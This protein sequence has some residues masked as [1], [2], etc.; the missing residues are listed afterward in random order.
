MMRPAYAI[1]YDCIDPTA[2]RPTLETKAVR[3]LYGA[4]Q[5]NGSSGYEEAAVQ[6]F[7]AGVNAALKLLG[8]EPLI[9]RRSR[10]LHRHPHRRPG[11]QGHP[12]ALP[13]D[14]QPH[15][16]TACCC[17]RTTQTSRLCPIGFRIGL[18][19]AERLR[20]VEEK[21]AAVEREI[22]RL[23]KTGVPGSAAL[24]DLLTARGTAPVADGCRLIDLLRRPQVGYDDL[25]PFDPAPPGLPP[26]VREQV[27]ITVKYEGY[28]RRQEKQVEEFEKLERRRLPPDMDYIHIQ[29][30]RLEARE[31]LAALRPENLGQAGRI[32]GVSPADIAALMVY[33][34]TRET[35]PE[36]GTS[37]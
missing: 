8:R 6:G 26:A 32:S 11:D 29:G 33:L 28:I 1:E 5:F 4:G 2:L 10:K 30:L 18:V 14:D 15:R 16:N 34:H 35:P 24:N 25:I 17:A 31:K 20:R 23:E 27:E 22:R 9:L 12:G 37:T 3:G 7:V 19:S 13:H 36:G 21:Y